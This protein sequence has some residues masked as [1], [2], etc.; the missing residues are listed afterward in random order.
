MNSH[1]SPSLNVPD[2]HLDHYLLD[3]GILN[4]QELALAKKLQQQQ[5]GPLPMILLRLRL[6]D[7]E[8][9]TQL[10]TQGFALGV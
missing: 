2:R 9:L 6:I 7:L 5:R 10:M 4:P 1:S 3:N 8:Q